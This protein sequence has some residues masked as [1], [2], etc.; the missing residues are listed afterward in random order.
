MQLF[1]TIKLNLT[2]FISFAQLMPF[3]R[4]TILNNRQNHFYYKSYWKLFIYD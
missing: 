1:S 3:K 4:G 2:I